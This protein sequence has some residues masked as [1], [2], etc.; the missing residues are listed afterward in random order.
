MRWENIE[1]SPCYED[2][3]FEFKCSEATGCKNASYV[4]STCNEAIFFAK[5][6][7]ELSVFRSRARFWSGHRWWYIYYSRTDIKENG[8]YVSY[9]D[10]NE[11]DGGKASTGETEVDAG[12]HRN[13]V[14][15]E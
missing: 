3:S 5:E 11:G 7:V 6:R 4:G 13:A 14:L 1:K 12:N 9:G 2:G 10:V 8:E 15:N